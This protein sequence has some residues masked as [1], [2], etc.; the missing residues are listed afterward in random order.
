MLRTLIFS[1]GPTRPHLMVGAVRDAKT[2]RLVLE[3]SHL[4]SP[5][6]ITGVHVGKGRPFDPHDLVIHPE[7]Y[8]TACLEQVAT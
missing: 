1:G 5:Q 6:E 4:R 3:R 7:L 8:V 2:V